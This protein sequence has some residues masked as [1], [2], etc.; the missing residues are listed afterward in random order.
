MRRPKPL[1]VDKLAKLARARRLQDPFGSLEAL[2]NHLNNWWMLQYNRPLKDPILQTYTL[3]E[4]VYEYFV[5]FYFQAENDPVKADK[6]AKAEL[7]EI[8]WAQRVLSKMQTDEK[9][10]AL[11]EVA[12]KAA[13]AAVAQTMKPSVPAEPPV[14]M[15]DFSV[16]F[17]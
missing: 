14:D 15:P 17:K 10:K 16:K 7:E 9:Q 12:A 4:L 2:R 5:H 1:N 6:K 3:Q 11:E 13:A 8:G